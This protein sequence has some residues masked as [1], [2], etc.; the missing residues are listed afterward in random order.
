MTPTL[1]QTPNGW[2][3]A[4]PHITANG[5]LSEAAALKAANAEIAFTNFDGEDIADRLAALGL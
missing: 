2:S 3:F 1:T 4:L 5:Y